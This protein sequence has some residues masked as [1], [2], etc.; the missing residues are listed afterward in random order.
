MRRLNLE[1]R[2]GLKKASGSLPKACRDSDRA[3]EGDGGRT[4]LERV[5]EERTGYICEL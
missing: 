5:N 1:L 4:S 3:G 2:I